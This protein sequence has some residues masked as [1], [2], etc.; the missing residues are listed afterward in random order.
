M[1]LESNYDIRLAGRGDGAK[2]GAANGKNIISKQDSK[3]KKIRWCKIRAT[4]LD[5]PPV[6]G[7]QSGSKPSQMS[8][9]MEPIS[10]QIDQTTYVQMDTDFHCFGK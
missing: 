1:M 9:K 2:V 5:S 10:E 8:S 6:L 4:T 7:A 3:L